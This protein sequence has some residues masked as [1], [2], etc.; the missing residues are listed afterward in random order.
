MSFVI[1]SQP[2]THDV[3]KFLQGLAVIEPLHSTPDGVTAQGGLWEQ[4]LPA[5]V[6]LDTA[7]EYKIIVTARPRGSLPTALWN[8]AYI[9]FIGDHS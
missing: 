2:R 1:A 5:N 8:S 6:A 4:I 3:H 9:V 7:D